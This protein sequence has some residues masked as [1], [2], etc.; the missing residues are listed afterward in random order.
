MTDCTYAVF[1]AV[2]FGLISV[3]IP[4]GETFYSGNQF[5]IHFFDSIGR[6]L[7]TKDPFDFF[8]LVHGNIPKLT[9][10]LR[11]ICFS[12]EYRFCL[13]G[14]C[15]NYVFIKKIK[16]H[17]NRV[18]GTYSS[19]SYFYIQKIINLFH[20]FHSRLGSSKSGDRVRGME[21]KI[22]NSNQLCDRISLMKVHHHVHRR[23]RISNQDELNDL[24]LQPFQSAGPTPFWSSTWNGSTFRIFFFQIYRQERSD[25]VTGI[26][27]GHLVK[28]LVPNEKYSA[29]L[30]MRLAVN[31]A[32]GIS[33]MVPT[34]NGISIP[35][36]QIMLLLHH[37][38]P[39][40]EL[41][42]HTGYRSREP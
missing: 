39:F 29:R 21:N 20:I 22:H 2:R 12:Y 1:T 28:S 24:Y 25:I 6:V 40:P 23:Y 18:G 34:L 27:E 36:F 3:E 42:I 4:I 11:G 7:R 30:A 8:V 35:S 31:A 16:C 32:R 26:T 13:V 37:G 41:R 38:S 33:I 15:I 14:K 19:I 10:I 5:G 9:V 17:K